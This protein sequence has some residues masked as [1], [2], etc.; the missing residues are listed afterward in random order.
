MT[1]PRHVRKLCAKC[2]Q[3]SSVLPRETR[4]KRQRFGPRSYWCYGDLTRV[5]K[6][7]AVVSDTPEEVATRGARYRQRATV[8]RV[9]AEERL[10]FYRARAARTER[11]V[12]KW[13]KRVGAA[14]RREFLDD[15]AV[16]V[17]RKR[18][19]TASMVKK[20]RR[21]LLISAGLA[22]QR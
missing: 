3:V 5:V 16:E 14:R 20:A 18:L 17:K 7:K 4:C 6:P 12:A 8:A 9:A 10:A 15:V 2:G 21:R 11:L 1:R 13:E 22:P 19:L